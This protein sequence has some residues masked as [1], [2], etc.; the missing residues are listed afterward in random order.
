MILKTEA[1]ALRIRGFSNTSHIVT[2]L[3]P[4]AGRLTTVV[5]GACRPKSAFLGQYDLFYS[6]ELLYYARER[7]GLHIARE[8]TPMDPRASFRSD[9]RAMLCASYA[10][11]AM[12]HVAE[13]SPPGG[14]LFG[15]LREVLDRLAKE[16]ADTALLLWFEARLL[17]TLGLS[18]DLAGCPHCHG[19]AGDDLR[20]AVADGR[21]VCTRCDASIRGAAILTLSR[22]AVNALRQAARAAEPQPGLF[23]AFRA[24]ERIVLR[25]FLGVF[26][27]Y[28]LEIPFGS[29]SL[30]WDACTAAARS[31]LTPPPEMPYDAP[32][33][34][35]G[36]GEGPC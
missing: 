27:R 21:M 35:A 17:E 1:I 20:F 5:K 30:A 14:S 19:Q 28:H 23:A 8:C 32:S 6:C 15:L 34:F 36:S 10:C 18:P 33:E 9:W 22:D 16:G 4:E 7:E 12:D 3:S 11:D 2:W 25:R 13:N 24:T 29:R 31:T 26:M